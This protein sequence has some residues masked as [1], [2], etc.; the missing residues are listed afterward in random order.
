MSDEQL[1]MTSD[2][3]KKISFFSAILIVIGG[4]VGAGIFLRSSSVLKES[5]GNIF[6]AIFAWLL[7]AFAV[8]TMAIAL[9]EVASGRNDN[10]G[11]IG[12][13]KAFNGLYI[14]KG[15]KWFMTFL[16]LP[17]TFYFMPLYVIIQ[18]QDA[19]SGFVS[20]G[21]E[22]INKAFGENDWII[23]MVIT[24][25]ISGW[26]FFT[27]G[28][29]SRIGNI[30]NWIVTSLKFIPLIVV[31]IL[32]LLFATDK[33]NS[34]ADDPTLTVG[35]QLL[36][37]TWWD[38]KASS[39]KSLSPI[40]GLFTS[41]AGIFFAYDGFYVTAGI[42][43]EMAEPKK[44]PLALV[45]GL[46]TVTF[47]YLLLAI[48][49]TVGAAK[50]GFYDFSEPLKKNNSGWMFGIINMFIAIGILGIIN[51]FVMWCTRFV[52]DLIK[53]GELAVP[54][55]IYKK[56]LTSKTPLVGTIYS[57][58]ISLPIVVIFN[59]IGSL[60]YF[61]D[62]YDGS[63]YGGNHFLSDL[64]FADRM[65]NWMAVIAFAFIA[66]SI[67]GALKNRK[68][69]WIQV[70]KGKHT[71]WAGWVAVTLVFSALFIYA[72]D[73][74]V[75]LGLLTSNGHKYDAHNKE[76]FSNEFIGQIVTSVLLPLFVLFMFGMVPIEKFIISKKKALYERKLSE[77]LSEQDRQ[78]YLELQ[79]FNNLRLSTFET[80]C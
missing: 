41:M 47:I 71:V 40:F 53:E 69:N 13:N 65:A 36:Q 72:L 59:V 66:L 46:S 30:Q 52:E 24:L 22:I 55:R 75:S 57:I 29:S 19:A 38:A 14:Y 73:S 2:K 50:G 54:H 28:L 43:S 44:T 27:A 20:G 35:Q 61:P 58:I 79:E 9:V 16:Y 15:C 6:W 5:G 33:L 18:M 26:F 23:M 51:G 21:G 56:M 77:N 34:K 37:I 64:T 80:V 17:F 49:M 42:Q 78:K 12:W 32:G 25:G 70:E 45:L 62:A 68:G 7:A 60:A 1:V 48:S 39:L 63:G 8:I 74:Y 31:V 11:M 4:S 76:L 67:F 3:K 10:L